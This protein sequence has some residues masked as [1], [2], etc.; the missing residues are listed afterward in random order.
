VNE[1]QSLSKPI[2]MLGAGGHAIVLMDIILS[3]G[4]EVIGVVCPTIEEERKAFFSGEHFSSDDDVFTFDPESILLVNGI[5][6]L[7]NDNGVRERLYNRFVSKGYKF[8]T[9]ISHNAIVSPSVKL[10]EG[11]QLMHGVI[12]QPG[13]YIGCNTI[14][15]TGALVDHDCQ[16][17]E[18]NHLA[19]NVTFS[20]HVTTGKKVHV[21]TGA[22]VIQNISIGDNTIVGA[23][24]VV[25]RNISEN[26]QVFG[27][28]S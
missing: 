6:S 1:P 14:V 8:A 9:V 28:R 4:S 19:P 12:V 26:S 20:G 10:G 23:G 22:S 7:P 27:F 2:L 21:G 3:Q 5:G 18:H 16:V 11:V 13:S 17:G 25:T 15:N 24:S